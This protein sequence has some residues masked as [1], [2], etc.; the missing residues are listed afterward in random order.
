MLAG[1]GGTAQCFRFAAHF[2]QGSHYHAWE[3]DVSPAAARHI[4]LAA[5]ASIFCVKTAHHTLIVA[6]LQANVE[7]NEMERLHGEQY[8]E[9]SSRVSKLI[10]GIF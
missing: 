3:V 2:W 6:Y 10:P 8:S 4:P 5:V 9:Y 7:E 1:S